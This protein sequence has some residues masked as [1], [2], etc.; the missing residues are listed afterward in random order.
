MMVSPE[1]YYELHIK[2]KNAEQ[3]MIVIRGL[4]QEIGYLKNTMEHPEYGREP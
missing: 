4:K 1:R 2:G 3:I